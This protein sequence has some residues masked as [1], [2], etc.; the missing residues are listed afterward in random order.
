MSGLP[1]MTCPGGGLYV[2][3]GEVNLLLTVLRR[4]EKWPSH[5]VCE[6]INIVFKLSVA[7]VIL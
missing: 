1:K 2:V 6:N 3:Q 7:V 4:G 5:K